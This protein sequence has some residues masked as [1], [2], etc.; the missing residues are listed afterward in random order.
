MNAKK[1]QEFI[2][3]VMDFYG[4]GGL[5]DFKATLSEVKKAIEIRLLFKGIEFDGDTLDRELV[6]DIILTIRGQ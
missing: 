1:L 5:Y 2:D 4:N 6:R 3:Y